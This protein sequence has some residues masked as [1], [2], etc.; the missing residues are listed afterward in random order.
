MIRPA[1]LVNSLPT[2]ECPENPEQTSQGTRFSGA[3]IAH[4]EATTDI[5]QLLPTKNSTNFESNDSF[6]FWKLDERWRA[7]LSS[8]IEQ[9]KVSA[10]RYLFEQY[11]PE[12]KRRPAGLD[13]YYAVKRVIP[14]AI[15]HRLNRLVV[16][17]RSPMPFPAWP[18]EATLLSLRCSWLDRA[19][20]KLR[21]EDG[22]YVGFWPYGNDCCIVLTHDVESR[23]G[24]S[25]IP[26]MA[27]VERKY[28][29]RSAWNI[30]LGQFPVDW[31]ELEI[32]RREGFELGAHGLAH[33]GR[34]FRSDE[35][36][37]IL[38]PEVERLAR[39]HGLRGF[40]SPST[41]RRIDLLCEMDF[42]FDSSFSDTDPYEPQPGGSCSTFPFFMGQ[43]VELP[44][45]LPQ[46]HTLLNLVG[47]HL[48]RTWIEKA[49][50]LS[51]IGA[52]ILVLTHPD[53]SAQPPAIDEYE[54]LLK[55]LSQIERAWR[56]LPS[57]VAAWWRTRSAIRLESNG[58]A[59]RFVDG[60]TTAASVKP[61]SA[62]PLITAW[63]SGILSQRL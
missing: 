47:R 15:R 2:W 16:S 25:Q 49:E 38:G 34:L 59:A 29:F 44:Y 54:E 7:E 24:L 42:D 53:Y 17:L 21:C 23:A 11:L 43:M 46:D 10:E 56:A 61:L 22:W 14:R 3:E 28:G 19:L 20:N 12:Q 58:Q 37:R 31:A 32:L 5:D 50:W 60:S 27:E 13:F 35:D 33:D 51:S 41:L 55:Y 48:S 62:D 30:P 36:F 57:E 8:D 39:A 52:M 18:Y 45:T 63:R 9:S 26:K 40:R 6:A 1:P 4:F